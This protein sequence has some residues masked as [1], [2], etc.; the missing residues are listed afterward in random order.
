MWGTWQRRSST[1]LRQRRDPVG[2]LTL[3]GR[4]PLTKG[5]RSPKIHPRLYTY[6]WLISGAFT[7]TRACFLSSVDLEKERSPRQKGTLY[8]L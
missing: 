4:Y 1:G 3:V 7:P 5:P 6:F 8:F 2:G